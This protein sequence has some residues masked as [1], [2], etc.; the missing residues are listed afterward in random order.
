MSFFYPRP[1]TI[2]RIRSQPITSMPT[3]LFK[4]DKSMQKTS[5]AHLNHWLEDQESTFCKLLGKGLL[6]SGVT[7]VIVGYWY[8]APPMPLP[9]VSLII[10]YYY[11]IINV[12][13]CYSILEYVFINKLLCLTNALLLLYLSLLIRHKAY[14]SNI[15]IATSEV[16]LMK[17]NYL[18]MM[19]MN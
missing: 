15:F 14:Q 18:Q 11:V 9:T 16:E 2:N 17:H 6:H 7:A 1:V 4:E 12:F 13:M 8:A 10:C 19:F 3:M 5:K